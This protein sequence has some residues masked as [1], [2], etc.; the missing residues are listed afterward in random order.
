MNIRSIF[1]GLACRHATSVAQ[2]ELRKNRHIMRHGVPKTDTTAP[3]AMHGWAVTGIPLVSTRMG[4][5]IERLLRPT[6]SGDETRRRRWR[7]TRGSWRVHLPRSML[8]WVSPSA[9][10]LR[11]DQRWQRRSRGSGSLCTRTGRGNA[12]VIMDGKHARE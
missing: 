8:R 7:R 5:S 12:R 1:D 10:D 9:L 11:L 6:S 4:R 2:S 3:Y